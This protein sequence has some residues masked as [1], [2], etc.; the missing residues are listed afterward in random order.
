MMSG[1]SFALLAFGTLLFTVVLAFLL[2]NMTKERTEL[3]H[4]IASLIDPLSGVPN[5]RAFLDGAERLLA[6]QTARSRAACGAV[7]RPRPLQGDQRPARPCGRRRGAAD[8]CAATATRTLGADVL[9]G[10]IGGEEFAAIAAAWATSAKPLRSPTAC[11]ANLRARLRR[12]ASRR[13]ACRRSASA[14]PSAGPP[15]SRC[16]NCWLRPIRRSIAPRPTAETGSKRKTR[17]SSPPR[18]LRALTPGTGSGVKRRPRLRNRATQA[19]SLRI[20]DILSSKRTFSRKRL[21]TPHR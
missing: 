8:V 6:Q 2:L 10:R 17:P 16:R 14:S 9:F 5:R 18:L 11:A 21:R 20:R 12:Y 13:R 15:N 19:H 7:V 4:K 3:Q 1:M